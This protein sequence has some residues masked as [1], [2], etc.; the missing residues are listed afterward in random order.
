MVCRRVVRPCP[1]V[2][3]L[4]PVGLLAVPPVWF[5]AQGNTARLVFQKT[6]TDVAV[7]RF[8]MVGA[9]LTIPLAVLGVR[10]MATL[11]GKKSRN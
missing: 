8:L 10:N 1:V 4:T 9:T 3:H 5:A 6:P 7:F 11:Q 2:G